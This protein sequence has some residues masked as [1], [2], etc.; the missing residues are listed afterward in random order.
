M[1]T[2][3]RNRRTRDI[4]RLPTLERLRLLNDE[5]ATVAAAVR[6][7]LPAIAAA[8][9][10]VVARLSRGGKLVYAGAGTSGR[11]GMLDA[12]ECPPTF[13]VPPELVRALIAGGP[14]ALTGAVEGAE[15]DY[16]A[17]RRD[18]RALPVTAAD[19]VVGLA[20]SGRTPYVLG[21]IDAANAIGAVTVGL[22]CNEPAPLLERAAIAIAV[23]VGPEA[24]TGST[25][26]KAGTA[27][28]MVLNMLS[29]GAMIGLGKVYGNLM[30]DVQVTNRKLAERARR[31]VMEVAGVDAAAAEALLERCDNQV[32]TAIVAARLGV[33]PEEGR[34]LLAREGG[35]LRRVIDA[36]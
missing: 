27:Q 14:A 29:T 5:D 18:L 13:G 10:S 2:E 9:D 20:A 23:P 24:I 7:A 19:V 11:L 36:P 12:V 25:R 6:R 35:V 28:K 26:L 34:R 17:G 31:M 30:V 16:E 8:V 21:A 32:K 22:S 3:E 33:T 1:Q 4:D 15:D